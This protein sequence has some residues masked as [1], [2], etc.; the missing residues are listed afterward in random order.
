MQHRN[1]GMNVARCLLVSIVL[2]STLVKIIHNDSHT[3]GNVKLKST[4]LH[5]KHMFIQS[6]LKLFFRI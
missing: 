1:K 2:H 5:A 4:S 3:L 6:S